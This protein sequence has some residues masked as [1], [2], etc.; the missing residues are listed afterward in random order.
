M[1]WKSSL[2]PLTVNLLSGALSNIPELAV[3]A[4]PRT[5]DT[6]SQPSETQVRMI[7]RFF[8]CDLFMRYRLQIPRYILDIKSSYHDTLIF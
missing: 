7:S 4:V 5:A 8:L 6:T 2:L 1:Y 3:S